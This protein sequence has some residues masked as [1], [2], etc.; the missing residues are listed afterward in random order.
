MRNNCKAKEKVLTLV[1]RLQ[2]TNLPTFHTESPD[3]IG[4]FEK[5]NE[6]MSYNYFLQ[7]GDI[8]KFQP[9]SG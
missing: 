8:R 9:V 6:K 7:Y 5:K 3:G 4:G 1:V 2:L